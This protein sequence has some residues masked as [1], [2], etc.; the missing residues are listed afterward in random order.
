MS[1]TAFI[2]GLLTHGFALP[3]SWQS[4]EILGE[5]VDAV[6]ICDAEGA[7]RLLPDLLTACPLCPILNASS[8]ALEWA[9]FSIRNGTIG[10]IMGAVNILAEAVASLP[11]SVRTSNDPHLLLAGWLASRGRPLKPTYDPGAR[12]GMVYPLAA[13]FPSVVRAAER[14]RELVS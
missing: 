12:S 13:R 6:F 5:R 3:P 4:K 11:K 9:D 1:R 14:L 7:S 10:S 8:T 2:H